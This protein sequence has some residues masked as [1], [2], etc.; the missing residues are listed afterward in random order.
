ML[1]LY[2]SMQ[3]LHWRALACLQGTAKLRI[4]SAVAGRQG[5][6]TQFH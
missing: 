1:K 4:S 5:K 3:T 2:K 6:E